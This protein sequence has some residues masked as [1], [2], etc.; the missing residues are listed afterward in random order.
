VGK[1]AWAIVDGG[2]HQ[3]KVSQGP[4]PD[5][6]TLPERSFS[7]V[8]VENR[9]DSE[10]TIGRLRGRM[11]ILRMPFLCKHREDVDSV[12]HTTA[13]VHN[14]LLQ[15]DGFSSKFD[16]IDAA[17][18]TNDVEAREDENEPG[19]RPVRHN[20]L[21]WR[22]TR[23]LACGYSGASGLRG[24][25]DTILSAKNLCTTCISCALMAGCSITIDLFTCDDVRMRASVCAREINSTIARTNGWLQHNH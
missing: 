9:K 17:F 8:V 16:D 19:W 20:G 2:Y 14:M 12:V 4:A 5:A 18:F 22:I 13:I 24:N 10:D 7:R 3:W 15:H 23:E 11:R 21:I 6:P 25:Q 1:G